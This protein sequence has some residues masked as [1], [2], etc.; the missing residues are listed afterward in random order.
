MAIYI[1]GILENG[2][3]KMIR[4]YNDKKNQYRD[5]KEKDV[6][7]LLDEETIKIKNADIK[8]N[9]LVGTTGSLKKITNQNVYTVVGY[10]GDVDEKP[11]AYKFVDSNGKVYIVR[12]VDCID[13]FNRNLVQ[14]A[15]IVDNK[16]IRGINWSIPCV[17]KRKEE[18]KKVENK[19]LNFEIAEKNS[20]YFI[21]NYLKNGVL[22]IPSIFEENGQKY[23]VVSVA[24]EAFFEYG[25][26][27]CKHV[28]FP[29]SVEKIGK[30]IFNSDPSCIESIYLGKNLKDFSYMEFFNLDN[31]LC[32]PEWWKLEKIT[33]SP[34]NQYYCDIDGVLFTKDK[35]TLLF[36]PKGRAS[37]FY[38][39]PDYTEK[40][41]S[42]AFSYNGDRLTKI[43]LGKSLIEIE[44]FAFY[45]SAGIVNYIVPKTLKVIKEYAMYTSLGGLDNI[46]IN[47]FYAGSETD[48]KLVEKGLH[49]VDKDENGNELYTLYSSYNRDKKELDEYASFELNPENIDYFIKKYS[50]NDVLDI[51]P[52]IDI[53][54]KKYSITSIEDGTFDGKKLKC[55]K[56]PDTVKSIN[57]EALFD[58]TDSYLE[59]LYIG[60]G[61]KSGLE[62]AISYSYLFKLKEIHVSDKNKIYC[63]Q[64]GVLFSKDMKVLIKYPASKEKD[65]YQVP[66]GVSKINYMAFSVSSKL[67]T[68]H[69]G[70]DV[71]YIETYALNLSAVKNIIYPKSSLFI[72]D[73]II[74]LM[75]GDS[76]NIFY[77]DAEFEDNFDWV[78]KMGGKI[79]IYKGY[80]GENLD[81]LE[82]KM[83][84]IKIDYN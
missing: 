81:S 17:E 55:I 22:D 16:F 75:D 27:I 79:R 57:G 36:Y 52:Y 61:L 38:K 6:L 1:I 42:F 24:D 78:E 59:S 44:D 60:A 4:L 58:E 69:F 29:D 62:E 51:P 19:I 46:N 68:L 47:I 50:K 35:K 67:K 30:H 73:Y 12:I 9:K 83:I 56:I 25:A 49:W 66:N 10:I 2:K 21:N 34:E 48:W 72:D 33:V 43:D 77:E 74:Q 80:N 28:K 54:G 45:I 71:E 65:F 32:Q 31:H 11:L 37:K 26:S 7:F 39:V 14:N 8:E 64:D 82:K 23:K 40:I 5:M 41:A 20:S 18:V 3:D 84:E 70:N 63:S 15:S 13:F 53:K 76:I